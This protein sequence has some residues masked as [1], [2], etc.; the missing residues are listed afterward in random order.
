[1]II[2]MIFTA[3]LAIGVDARNSDIE[4]RNHIPEVREKVERFHLHE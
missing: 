3:L 4:K 1:M 2:M